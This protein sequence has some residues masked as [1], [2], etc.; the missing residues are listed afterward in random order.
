MDK[1]YIIYVGNF[2]FPL[3]NASGKRVYGN[4]CI[5]R[6]LGYETIFIGMDSKVQKETPLEETRKTY[7]GFD[8]YNLNYP[9]GSA[10]WLDFHSVFLKLTQWLDTK[11]HQIF[12]IVF[13]GS[14][15]LSPFISKMI[16][17]AR[18]NEI[19]TISDC[20]DWL[21]SKTGN[22]AFDVVKN[23]DTFYQKA[24]ANKKADGIICISTYLQKYYQN[25]HKPT[26]VIPPLSHHI[27]NYIPTR[28]DKLKFVYAGSP[29]RN[30]NRIKDLSNLKDRTDKMVD[31]LYF[32]KKENIQF[33]MY[34]YGLDKNNF[35]CAFPDKKDYVEYLGNSLIFCG[36]CENGIVTKSIE[37][38]DFTILIRDKT[39][40]T[41]AG[42]PTKV[43]ESISYGTPVITT[44]TSDLELYLID[45]QEAIF[46]ND[47]NLKESA[48]QIK[49][50]YISTSKYQEMKNQCQGN[51]TFYFASF[52]ELMKKFIEDL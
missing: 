43:S 20:V 44:K 32:M 35:L 9:A 17:W 15:R 13:Y 37:E 29:F 27:S 4:G 19:K 16:N 7:D 6:E 48:K 47:G 23:L 45:G 49:D 10:E 52:L 24:I 21:E 18:K 40:A 2:S 36:L 5:F 26:V 34:Y 11:K 41:M 50:H 46:V 30:N 33:E 38:A 28:S 25:Q 42:F 22:L 12:A 51:T 31:L 3:G 14:L 8:Y 1:K 39:K